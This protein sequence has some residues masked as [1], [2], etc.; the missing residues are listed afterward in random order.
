ML[1]RALRRSARVTRLW[2]LLSVCMAC[3]PGTA[4]SHQWYIQPNAFMQTY[5]NDNLRLTTTPHS[6]A[7]A[8]VGNV[9]AN[10][11]V[12]SQVS[13]V[14]VRPNLRSYNYTGY[15]G[16]SN[17]D[18]IAR[19]VAGKTYY[20]SETDL[21][22][23]NGSYDRDSTLT[24]ELLDS[25]RVEFNIP[26]ERW[27]V[28]PA[29]SSQ[30]TPRG[31]I[32][33]EGGYTRTSY[34]NGLIYGLHDYRVIDASATYA[35]NLTETQQIN[36]TASASRFSAPAYFDDRT[37][38]YI[39]QMGW[40]SH[41]TERTV[42]SLSGGARMN[43]TRLKVFGITT[44]HSQLG[45]VLRAHV[46]T[47]SERTNWVAEFRR[48]VVPTSYGILMQRDRAHAS[49]NRTLSFYSN[50]S[51]SGLWLHSKDLQSSLTQVSRTLA[52]LDLSFAWRFARRW[53]FKTAYRWTWQDYGQ[54]IARSNAVFLSLSYR[55]LERSTSY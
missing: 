45:Y 12:R 54:A 23:L 11:G 13:G 48:D 32:Q 37:D 22:Q 52:R 47:K 28:Q 17:Y 4:W 20:Q 46:T 2:T 21:W 38:N 43:R 27:S 24:S 8:A 14:S 55:G 31:S 7:W 26:R 18:H 16:V 10:L 33:L 29:W 30:W 3:L 42:T 19:K 53:T 15:R 36:L 41:W 51:L 44:K 40:V 39:A 1:G 50:A 34:R 5:Y 35:Y 9:S 6:G 25:G 49:V